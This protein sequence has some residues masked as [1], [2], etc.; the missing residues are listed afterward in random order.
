[1]PPS[2]ALFTIS[3]H[4]IGSDFHQVPFL[5]SCIVS[6]GRPLTIHTLPLFPM[7]LP[8]LIH[9]PSYLLSHA[10]SLP[11]LLVP[12]TT[13][14]SSQQKKFKRQPVVYH[15]S[16][17]ATLPSRQ[18]L[19]ILNRVALQIVHSSPLLSVGLGGGKPN[20]L[21]PKNKCPRGGR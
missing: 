11:H 10:F 1:M 8:H 12:L 18:G 13:P 20:P 9:I 4:F 16:T 5:A 17:P 14:P 2:M 3:P 6:Y 15:P 21:A 19:R 7:T